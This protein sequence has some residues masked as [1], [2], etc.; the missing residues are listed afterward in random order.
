MADKYTVVKY[1]FDNDKFEVLV[2]PDPALDY[3]LGKIKDINQILVSD[4]IYSDVGKGTRASSDKLL[5]AFKTEDV[6]SIAEKILQK[7]VLNLTTDQRRKMIAEKRKQIITFIS[8]TF[9]DPHSHLP[10]PPLRVEQAMNDARVS[11]DP[12]KNSEEQIKDL[13]LIHI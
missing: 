8:K 5:K 10:H 3:K 13:S 4:E 6:L 12:F 7:G 2:K 9:V 1:T 11:I